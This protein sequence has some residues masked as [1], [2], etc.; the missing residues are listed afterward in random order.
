MV[1]KPIYIVLYYFRRYKFVYFAKSSMF[2]FFVGSEMAIT[3]ESNH[4]S[5]FAM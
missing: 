2:L 4:K 1:E 5:I 3:S